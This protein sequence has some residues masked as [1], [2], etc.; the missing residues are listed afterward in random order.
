MF[1]SP[2]FRSKPP[3]GNSSFVGEPGAFSTEIHEYNCKGQT[4]ICEFQEIQILQ[5]LSS[6]VRGVVRLSRTPKSANVKLV[7]KAAYDQSKHQITFSNGEHAI[8]PADFV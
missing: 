6:V 3:R 7:G 8:I 5:A 1:D 4:F 2:A